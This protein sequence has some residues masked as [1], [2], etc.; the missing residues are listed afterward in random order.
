NQVVHHDI[1]DWDLVTSAVQFDLTVSGKTVK[2][3]G[4]PSKTCYLYLWD[5]ETGKPINPIVETSMP[6]QTDVP[7]EVLWPTQP[8]PCT[9]RG[10][11]V[12]AA[13]SDFT[14]LEMVIHARL[15]ERFLRAG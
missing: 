4:A 2:G 14:K 12:A 7:G 1:W 13:A 15:V 9:S 6:T 5:R 8:I 3:I 11:M 10:A